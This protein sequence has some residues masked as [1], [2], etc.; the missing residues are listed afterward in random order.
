KVTVPFLSDR[1][2]PCSRETHWL[3]QN[4]SFGNDPYSRA[5]K[6][7]TSPRSAWPA[8]MEIVNLLEELTV[9]SE[10]KSSYSRS[11]AT[12]IMS[13]LLAER[14]RS[15][16]VLTRPK[17]LI[18]AEVLALLDRHFS[19]KYLKNA[20]RLPQLA[21]Y[22]I[23]QCL[24]TSVG[25]YKEFELK[26]LERLKAA[27]KKAG[28]VGDVVL[29]RNGINVEAAEVKLGVAINTETIATAIDK[30]RGASVERY[31]VLS[32]SGV[33][34][35]DREAVSKLCFDFRKS[36]GCEIIVNGVE[37]TIGYYLRLLTSTGEFIERYVELVGGDPDLDY[38]HREVWNDICA[39][40]S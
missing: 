7:T 23:Y 25:R 36:N 14:N 27:D 30:I 28:T 26:P 10:T 6:Y 31:Y 20:P 21:L 29:S 19:H 32:T 34:D 37:Q 9:D 24:I 38:Q 40:D 35:A 17:N 22:A 1:N 33:A 3:T 39:G 15:Q 4:I 5:T 13:G 12:L 11:V 2:L 18:I 16:V 8:Y